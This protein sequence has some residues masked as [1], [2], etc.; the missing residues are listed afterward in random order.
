MRTGEFAKLAGLFLVQALHYHLADGNYADANSLE[1]TSCSF[2]V[3]DEKVCNTAIVDDPCTAPFDGDP[4]ASERFAHFA[5]RARTVFQFNRKILQRLPPCNR[6][7]RTKNHVEQRFPRL[8]AIVRRHGCFANS[9]IVGLP[10]YAN[11]STPN[12]V[13]APKHQFL[14][15]HSSFQDQQ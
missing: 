7:M 10:C 15:F 5:E 2:S 1:R 9:L 13:R 6:G 14:A 12:M 8:T 3:I 4:S 11:V